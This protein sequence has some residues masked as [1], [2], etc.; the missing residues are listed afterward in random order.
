MPGT[1]ICSVSHVFRKDHDNLPWE[2]IAYDG[3]DD[4]GMETRLQAFMHQAEEFS[5]SKN[6]DQPRK[7][8]GQVTNQYSQYEE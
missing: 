3:Q 6:L 8:K 1:L 7:W 5:R 2:N 4:S